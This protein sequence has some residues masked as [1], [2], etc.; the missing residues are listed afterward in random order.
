[1]DISI[2][3]D[4]SR[5]FFRIA[6]TSLVLG[7]RLAELC[8]QGPSLEESVAL[9]NI[10]LD[11]FGRAEELYAIIA[12]IEG[13]QHTPDDYVY[14]RDERH[15]YNIKLVEQPNTDFSWTVAR[16]FFHDVYAYEVFTQLLNNSDEEVVGLAQ[17]VTKEIA[18][19]REHMQDWMHRLGLGTEE[20]NKRLQRAVDH[21]LRYADEMFNFDA[22]DRTHFADC[23]LIEKKWNSEIDEVLAAVHIECKVSPKLSM[24]DFRDGFHSEYLGELLSTMQYLPR[25]YPDAKW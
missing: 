17:K 12:R 25:T 20:S 15:Y 16:Q 14:R 18:Y 23:D 24:R 4:T 2:Q 13:G 9:S 8:T 11:L 6:D 22:L 1:M 3:N 19:S 21:L 7:Q 5:F 10:S